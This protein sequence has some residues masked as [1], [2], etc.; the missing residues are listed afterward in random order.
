MLINKTDREFIENKYHRTDEPF[1]SLK[2]FIY[3]GTGYAEETGK[4]DTEILAGLKELQDE[5]SRMSHPK[6]RATAIKYVLENERIYVNEHDYFVGLYSL[7]RLANSVTSNVW[8]QET[9]KQR[10]PETLKNSDLFNRSGA[11]ANWTD[12][13][14]V[15][16]DW[17]SLMNLGFKGIKERA[18]KYRDKH[19]K[20]QTLTDETAAFFEGID[21][22]YE[23]IIS[24]IDRMYKYAVTLDN[25]KSAKIAKCLKALRDG[26]PTDIYE[27]MQLILIYFLISECVDGFQVRSL[28][29]GLDRTLYKF[30]ENDLK[31][32]K[33]T[34][35]EIRTLLAYFLLQWSA[36]GNYWGQPF[37]LGGTNKDESTKYN[38]LSYDILDV[39][40][41][42]EIYNPK[43][44]LKVN[45][46]T[47]DRLLDKAFDMVRRKNASIVFCCEP[48]LIRSVMGYGATYDEALDMDIRG[49]YETGVR[50]NEPSTGEGYINCAKAVEYVFSNGLDK[51]IN[52]QVGIKTGELSEFVSFEDF[53]TAFI[54]QLE[55]LIDKT[56]KISNDQDKFLSFVNP[57]SMYSATTL[58]ALECGKDGYFNG[59]KFNNTTL[60]CCSFA[61]TVDCLMAV[62]KFVYDY[63]KVSLT[64][65]S[66]AL[67]ANWNGYEKL[68]LEIRNDPHK[69]GNHDK[70][71]DIYAAALADFF[72]TR[73]SNIQNGRGGI[74]KVDMH[75][76]REFIEQGEKTLASADGR[77]AGEL[78][79]KNG[80]PYDGMDK[81]GATALIESALNTTPTNFRESFGL[82]VML[83]PSAV[84]G[85]EGLCAFKA[86][87]KTYME[88]GGMT[89]QFNVFNSETLRD[90]QKNPEKYK[91]LQVRVCGWN[92]LWNNL[93]HE[94]QEAYIKR[95]ENI[96]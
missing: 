21:T 62:K 84:E 25:E 44:Q 19:A 36:I 6:A 77:K 27:A 91:N 63:K 59:L 17:E 75:S 8:Q 15:V 78:L 90:A 41:E 38:E 49:C 74:Y 55:Y 60:L 10:D 40:D 58:H 20:S 30:Y 95:A 68:C 69:Y 76:A 61:S 4:D 5:L 92:V 83:H 53:Y 2:R 93:S 85:D 26:A 65:L 57:S 1:D 67:D 12:Y 81:N 80:T 94:E 42:L 47:P 14:H 28:G 82:D 46:N 45:F 73:V 87:L 13:D 43:I 35:D 23:A 64:E 88:N 54:K 52:E 24:V 18:R 56:I 3:H 72:S 29:N 96:K 16:P 22:E 79:S 71:T 86:L 9:L 32:G 51:G 70:E 66:K 89:M 34:R 39:Y 50:A 31:S 48:G 33:Y 37:Y 7:G 11:V